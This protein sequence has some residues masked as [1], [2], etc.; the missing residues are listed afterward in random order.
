[1]Q[2][3]A[4]DIEAAARLLQCL[5]EN[6]EDDKPNLHLTKKQSRLNKLRHAKAE[7]DAAEKKLLQYDPRTGCLLEAGCQPEADTGNA[8]STS[9]SSNGVHA[10]ARQPL[11]VNVPITLPTYTMDQE[12]MVIKQLTFQLWKRYRTAD[13]DDTKED[14]VDERFTAS[15][16]PCWFRSKPLMER[17]LAFQ[18]WQ[19]SRPRRGTPPW[20]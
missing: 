8:A 18:L 1:M 16:A 2:Q 13:D 19:D 6:G 5:L 7:L 12:R 17:L 10:A 20:R 11:V 9:A 14:E 15:E 3:N 4:V